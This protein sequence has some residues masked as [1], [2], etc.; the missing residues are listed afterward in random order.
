MSSLLHITRLS[1]VNCF[2]L[3]F[4][5]QLFANRYRQQLP[6]NRQNYCLLKQFSQCLRCCH[7]LL[8]I[9]EIVNECQIKT[10]RVYNQGYTDD[11][12]SGTGCVVD[13]YGGYVVTC[14]HV[15][16]DMR[17]V[18]PKCQLPPNY[19]KITKRAFVLYVEPYNE[20]ALIKICYKAD[21]RLME[22]LDDFEYA[23]E[24]ADFGEHVVCLGYPRTKYMMSTTGYINSPQSIQIQPYFNHYR[25]ADSFH[26]EHTCGTSNGFSG[27]PIIDESGKL[28]GIH[29]SKADRNKK[30]ANPTDQLSE[31]MENSIDFLE[32]QEMITED[33]DRKRLIRQKN[34]FDDN[35]RLGLEIYW[36]NIFY[37]KEYRKYIKMDGRKFKKKQLT[38]EASGIFVWTVVTSNEQNH[39]LQDFDIIIQINYQNVNSI[40]DLSQALVAN[41]GKAIILTV[42]RKEKEYEIPVSTDQMFESFN[43]I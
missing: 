7:Q 18:F 8:T 21:D 3:K 2:A 20:L 31:F 42:I 32:K 29:H 12:K 40:N 43:S 24:M 35:R 41:V 34:T 19:Q 1:L 13:G 27:S 28:I 5:H 14:S 38:Y 10:L 11:G 39:L 17:T 23:D 22:E 26:I 4:Y 9:D 36:Y 33:E 15:V 37:V 16:G 30:F 6:T 25:S